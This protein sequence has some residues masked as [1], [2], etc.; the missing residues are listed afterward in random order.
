MPEDLL[1]NIEITPREVKDLAERGEKF[2]FV[3][4]REKWEFD[5]ARIEGARLIPLRE[6][7][8]NLAAFEDADQVV[9]YCHHG[10][11]SLDA[12]AWLRS[13]G[14]AGAKSMAGG[15]DRWSAEIDPKVPRY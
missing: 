3:D 5:T 11:R 1:A 7:P 14:V 2:L 12:A 13:Q 8:G 4:V 9:L 6:V 10:M 15:I